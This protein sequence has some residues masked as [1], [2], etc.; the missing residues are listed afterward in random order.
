M[1]THRNGLPPHPIPPLGR[2]A[3]RAVDLSF[4]IVGILALGWLMM[5]AWLA[6]TIDTGRNGLF[7]QDRIGRDG[8]TFRV[9]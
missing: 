7:M 5:A 3:K 1:A 4:A 6:A 9:I 8:R 2:A